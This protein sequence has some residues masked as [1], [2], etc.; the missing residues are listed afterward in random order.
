VI[1]SI[2]S[3]NICSEKLFLKQNLWLQPNGKRPFV[4]VGLVNVGRIMSN[5]IDLFSM[6]CFTFSKM[7][8]QTNHNMW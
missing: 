2:A 8:Y 7:F 5:D 3:W 6:T 1:I 4:Y